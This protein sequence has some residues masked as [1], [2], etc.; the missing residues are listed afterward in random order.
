[1]KLKS[2]SVACFLH[3]KKMMENL[4]S[5]KIKYFQ[6]DGAL[7]LTKGAF[8][9]VLDD[10]GIIPR[11]SCPHTQQQNGIAKCKHHH[12]TKLGLSLMF[13]SSIPKPYWLEAFSTTAYLI[14][15]LPTLVLNSTSPYEVLFNT[16][17]DYSHLRTFG[18]ACYPYLGPYKHDKLSPKSIFC[19]FLGYSTHSKGYRCLDPNTDRI[20]TS[21]HVVFD[22]STFSFTSMV[23]TSPT[24]ATH[25]QWVNLPIPSQN[26]YQVRSPLLLLPYHLHP[27]HLP[28]HHQYPYLN[29]I[30]HLPQF[31]LNLC[32]TL[33]NLLPLLI[34][35]Y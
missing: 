5:T 2:D 12:N 28:H 4:L 32:S 13:H 34:T 11:I 23:S 3:F 19:V 6:S 9:F 27:N 31:N 20:Y 29:P 14:N 33:L 21:R 26:Y 10:Y 24:L 30:L 7:E 17:P 15:R 35:L 18:C 8:K 22:E 16:R 1:M 25:H